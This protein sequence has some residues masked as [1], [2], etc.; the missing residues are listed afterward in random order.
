MLSDRQKFLLKYNYRHVIDSDSDLVSVGS[1]ESL[2][3]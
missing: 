1:A 3:S 2:F